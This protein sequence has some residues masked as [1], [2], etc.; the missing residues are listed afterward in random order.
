MVLSDASLAL[1]GLNGGP[2]TLTPY[3]HGQLADHLGIPKKYYDRSLELKPDLLAE[4]INVWLMPHR[5]N[6]AGERFLLLGVIA[7]PKGTGPVTK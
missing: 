3:A 2:K 5:T 7:E 6:A 1:T 4:N